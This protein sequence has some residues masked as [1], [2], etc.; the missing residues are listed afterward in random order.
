M[1]TYGF[2]IT[3]PGY[4]YFIQSLNGGWEVK[5][6]CCTSGWSFLKQQTRDA[7]SNTLEASEDLD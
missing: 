7:S 2:E 5:C 1:S 4:S 3:T 6:R